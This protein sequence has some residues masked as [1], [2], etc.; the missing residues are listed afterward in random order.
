MN[1]KL[2]V[3]RRI[4]AVVLCV[5]LLSSQ[6]V[7]ANAE[8]SEKMGVQTNSEIT[9]ISEQDGFS[10]DASEISDITES[11]IPDSFEGESEPNT[12][13]SSEVTEEFGNSEDQG[14]TDGEET[15]IEDENNS[16]TLEEANPDYD[17]GKIC[18]Y[19]YQQLLQIGTG[20][21]MFSG[22]KDGNVGEGDK[23]LADGVELTYASDASYC[24][25]NDIP[26]DN[27]NVWNFPS[28]F[29]GSITSSSERTGNT[30]YDSE[31]DTIYIYNRYQLELMKG[32]TSDS[33]PVMSEDYIAEK[34]G[35]GQVFTLEDGSYLTYSKTHNY[36]LASSF[37]TETPELLANKAGTEETTQN[38]TNAYPS[39]YEGRNYFGQVVKKIGDKNYILIGN[40]TQLRAIGTDVEVTEPIWRVYETREKNGGALS[41]YT[42]W[43]PAAD[44]QT[45]KTE[46]YYPGDADI[47]KFNDTYNWSGKELYANKNGAHKLNDT[48][49]LDNPSWDIAG[50][51]ATQ[52]YV[53]VSSTIQESADMT[54][55]ATESTA[56]D[57][58]AASVEAD[59]TVNDSDLIDM[60]PSDSE[61]AAETGSDDAEAFT[62]SGDESGFT[63]DIDSESITVDENKT[64]VLTYDTSKHS[65]T[66]IAGTGYKYSKDANYII[67][68]DIDLSKEGTNSNGEDDD[69][70]PIDNYQGNMEGRKGMVEGQNITISHIN[71]SQTNPV[72][73]DKQAEYGIGFFRNLTTPY[74]TS[75]TI[76]QNPI[77]VKNIT[78]SDVTVSTTTTKVK[79]NVS[80]I[81]SVLKLLLGNLSGL[82]PD[83][84]SLATGGFAGV[85]K[86]NIQIENCNVENL[87]GVSNVN[88]RT[89]GFAG[90]I[91][92]MTQYDLVSSGLG[93]LVGTLTK[94]LNLIP[95]LGV[96]DLLTVLLKGGLLSVDKLIPVGYVNPSI[97]NCSVSG[98]TSVTGQKSTGGFAGEAIGAVMKNCSVGGTTT[99]SGN[100]CSGGFVGRSAN[101]VVA[102]A[103]SSLGIEVMGNF[104]VN[105]VMLN[106]RIDGAVNV[107]AQG[108]PSK[109]S[110]YAGGF[111]GEMRNS[112][113]VDCSISSLG[114]VSGKD[115][116]GGFAGIATLGDVADI[117]ES[118]GLLVIVKDL[119]TGLL[120]GKFTNMDLLNLVG[121]RPS[122]ISGC[123]IAG[124]NIS[125]TANGKNAGGLVG[126]AGAVQISNTSE[127]TDDSKSTTKALQ[128]VLNK[129]GVTYEFADRVNQIN[130]ASSV[131]ISAT[132]NAGGILGYAKMTSVGD[133]LGG[134]VTA[135]DYM[136]FE[137]KD[138]SV[139]GGSSGLT[140]TASDQENGCAG[141]AIGYG[142]GGEVR[143]TSV[144]NLNFVT[145]G[146]CAGGFAGY[147]GS[148]TLANVGGIKLLGLPLLK[149]DSLLSV[150]QMIET[151]TVDSTVSGVTSGYSVSTQ[152]EKGYSGGFIGECISGRARDTQI[153]NLKT[154]TAS[155]T[156]GKAGGFA[157]FAKAGDALSAGDSTTS[158]LTG[159][160]LENLLGVVSALRPEFNNTSIAYVSKGSDPQVSADMAGGF[161][162]DG[163]AVD[164]NYGNN[165]SGF[166]A[167]TNSEDGTI[168]GESGAITT[169]NITGLSYIKG[170]SYAGGFAGRLMPGD[171]AQTGSIKLLGLLNVTQLLSVMDVAYPRISDSS[172]EGDS[173][174]VTASGKNDDVALGDAG[175][176]IGNGKAVMVKNSDVTNVKEVTAPYHAGGYIGIMRSGSAAEAGD[177]TGDLL[178]SVLGKI[179]SL[180][181]LAS[182]LQAASSQITNCKVAGIV[183]GLTVTADS[184]FEN[185][186][187]YAGGFVGEMQS[188][189]VDNA[190][191]AADSGKGTAVENLLKVEGLRYAGGFGGL[192]K[193]GAVAEIGAKS[194]I[195]TKV[196][197]LTGLLSMVNAFV[198]VI[199]NASVCSVKDGFTVHVT[200]T[201]EKDSTNDADAGSAGGFIGCGTGVQISNSDVNKLQH[202][203]VSEPKNLQQEDGSS[204]YGSDSAYAVSGYRYAGGYIGKAAMGSTAAIGGASVLDHVLSA[205]NLL[206]A[207]TVV[208]SIIDSSDVYGAIGGFNVLATDGDGDTGK[209]GGYAGELLGVQIQNSN[210]Y[211]FAHIIGR[212]SAGGYVGT[213]EPGSAADVVDGLSA[214]GGLIKADN[215][216]GVL[217]AFVPVIKNSETTC[218][219]CGGAV[220]AQAE[221]DD[222]IY[223]GLAG[224]YAGYNYGGQI[225][226]NNADNW[227]GTAY[228]GTV[229]E[230]A[231]YRIRSVYGTEYAGGYTGLM[232]CANVADTGSLKVL[233]GL[234]KLDN[235][236]T[237]L[238]AVYP[239][240]KNTAVYGPLRGLDTDTWN[241]WVGAVGSYG[242]Y[243][244][245]L[246]ALGE[247]NDQEQLNEIISQ[248]AYGYAVTAGRSILASKATQGG[249]AGG[250]VGRMEGGTITNGTATDLQLAEAYRSSGGFAGEMLTGSVANTGGVSLEDL[251]II[252]ADSLAALK[253][254]VPVVK[255]SHVEGYR[256]GAR[257]KATG[258]ADKDPAGFAG[259][260]VGRMIGGQI[261]GDETSSCSITNLRR[262]DGTSYVGGFAGKVDP[263]SVAAIDTATKQGLLNKLLDV[264]MVNAPAELIKVLNA[265]VST[266]RC[267]SV[268][269]WDDWGVIVN[270]TYQ[271]GSNTGYAK[272]AGGFA[273]SLCGAVLGEKDK[274]ESGIRADKIRSVVAGEYAGGCFGIADVSGAA[275]ISAG[276]ETSVLQ[277]LLKLG[278]TDVLDAFRSY[279]YYGNVTGSPDAG[280]GVSANTATDAGQNNQVTYSGT[281]GGFGGSL[282]NGSVKN[283]SVTGLNYVTGLNSVGGFVGYS[284]KSGV[285]KMEKL[286][287]LGDKFGQL[288]GGALGV[289]DIFGSHIDDSRVTGVPGGYTVQSKGGKEQIAGGFIGYAN[290]ARMSGCNAGDD[291]NQENSLKL[292]ESGGTA[293]GF[294]GRT[295]FAYLADVKLDSTVVDALFVVLD[296]LVRALYLD[297]IQDSDLLHINLGIVKVDALYEGNLLHVN[298]LG[299]DIS[300]GLSKMSADNDQQTDFAIIKIGDSSIKLPCDKNGI[301]TKDNDVKSNISV[302]LIK[303]NRTKITD[304]NVYGISAGYD[305]Y[306][307]G[308]GNNN[309]G[310]ATKDDGRSGGFVGFNDEGLLKNNNMYYCDVVR[311]TKGLVGPFSGKSELNS[312]YEFNTKAGVEGENNNYRIYRKPAIA[313]DK[314]QKNSKL[315][316]DTF[317]QENGWSIFSIKHVVQVDEYDTLQNAVMATKNS[318]ETE[319][320]NA[321]V[322]DAKAVLMADTNTSLNTGGSDTPE[323]SDVQDPCD[324]NVNLTINKIWK[325][326]C[327]MAG[328]RPSSITIT[329]FKTWTDEEGKEHTEEVAGYEN[330]E[331]IGDPSKST[332][333][334][335]IKTLPVYTKDETGTLH[336]YKYLVTEK[337]V[338]GYTTII[339]SSGDGFTFTIINRN[340]ALLPDTG[341]KG[342]MIFIMA[343]GVLLAFLLYTGRRRKKNV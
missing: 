157:G 255:Q 94:I 149:I 338:P 105:T 156:S 282:L 78:L 298:L 240:E 166:K 109:E 82:K 130:A 207:L 25:M 37:T 190:A 147:F 242:S 117:D 326:F 296:Q 214:L 290:L 222:S 247:V 303:A 293:G 119:L 27:E 194:S 343:G 76:S 129:T 101:A 110:G 22:D 34:V 61:E 186:E 100:D 228:T 33:E 75:L 116:T 273:G 281:A 50:T 210:S 87:H 215:L 304:S 98:G 202:T 134:T 19:N 118:Q 171:V 38:I 8:D 238:Q 85:V 66:N 237:L 28:D 148:G 236:L 88:D 26:I 58:E 136:R 81:G 70:D 177:A 191:N 232:R 291:Q 59:E 20:T 169:T 234:I 280:L 39:D 198:P 11:D 299:L 69:W 229:R 23:V 224:G 71:I 92:G 73:Q 203:G 253:T 43:K 341:G 218:V 289:L 321:Y 165:N 97:Q 84:Q 60:I 225:W 24:L 257:I 192:V 45:Y 128:R 320:L 5:T 17:D 233:F 230:C 113:A 158:Q 120:N 9:D 135:A 329:I 197:D 265:T 91:S 65:N 239:T 74:S 175:G 262:V 245:K 294:A 123:T 217:Q 122:V 86:G 231:A 40:E 15:I 272:A 333:Q 102:G 331:I 155:A 159:I 143:K 52:C 221:S 21:Q 208:A 121:L 183:D 309:D 285:V 30:V 330:Y 184:G 6:V 271:N 302:N 12:D 3:F 226:G 7:V 276:G 235:P 189:H 305:V 152:N 295:S 163:Q 141:G 307:G 4:T 104:P 249:S 199:S 79:Q 178:N 322:S 324:E 132:E 254:F 55:T 142:T 13:I 185:A 278:K 170:T 246:Q 160:E 243:G 168:E 139:N 227:K 195:L 263:G 267:A 284:G 47:V 112:Y 241:K 258:I 201:L 173:L 328:D 209:A 323:P 145:A 206:S 138:C 220:R 99:V 77:T 2:S 318:A 126:Y 332:W 172:I 310:D 63:D 32:E 339:E 317:N 268:S 193:A 131:K 306:A 133:V 327:K 223:R 283:S 124:D 68:R 154:V 56:S 314:I 46:L 340:F 266:I 274:P 41:G 261:W 54:V 200:G 342:I 96:G 275:N 205:T 115:Y 251:K 287:V 42:D 44:T 301:I 250:Y 187:G 300:V 212:E 49:Y 244:N 196:V 127:L 167:D 313:F 83:P 151:F 334:K 164:I 1:K 106:C 62:S 161:V 89:G 176:Y 211:N 312:T 53:Y 67:F 335:V 325:D 31:T 48:E 180:K 140:V 35:M 174:V 259:G 125:V 260:Y 286:D 57:S 248:Y 162:G 188:G 319:N 144:T 36:V 316:T 16:D 216:L 311:G 252:G 29:T 179:L 279:V 182:V 153:S 204:Y 269:A 111:I 264:L 181:E 107:S 93:G 288:L 137:C 80:L 219:P 64:Y 114:T 213:M 90:Y 51:K 308:A 337:E 277:Y 14:F 103:L 72:D 95:L 108:T 315:L 18:I 292:V 270:G 256:S 10:S 297:K 150:G 146:K 336:Y